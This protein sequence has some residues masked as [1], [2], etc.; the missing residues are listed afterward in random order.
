VFHSVG[1]QC[2]IVG[3]PF[4]AVVLGVGWWLVF[5]LRGGADF[6]L[7]FFKVRGRRPG[8]RRMSRRYRQGAVL[9]PFCDFSQKTK[10]YNRAR[11]A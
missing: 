6:F 7:I 2:V 11:R 3:K 9:L 4:D 5:G 1:F 10:P 8:P